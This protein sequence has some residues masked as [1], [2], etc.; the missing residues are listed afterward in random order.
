MRKLAESLKRL[1]EA[2]KV[3]EEQIKAMRKQ[4]KISEEEYVY[5]LGSKT[6]SK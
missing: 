3:R 4:G 1:Y 5:I 6:E 2:E